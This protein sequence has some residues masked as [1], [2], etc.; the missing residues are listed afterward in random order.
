MAM[1]LML[2][3]RLGGFAML[4][5]RLNYLIEVDAT[6]KPFVSQDRFYIDDFWPDFGVGMEVDT[7][8]HHG[9][10]LNRIKDA[11][12]R[13][14]LRNYG[15]KIVEATQGDTSSALGIAGLCRQLYDL[16]G[17]RPH[18]GQLDIGPKQTELVK[19]VIHLSYY[20]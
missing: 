2:P 16:L 3:K 6:G 1:P 19:E 8:M 4:P 17:I 20:P 14:A 10:D 13:N 12:R 15:Y 18:A 11:R 5:P 7:L 9:S